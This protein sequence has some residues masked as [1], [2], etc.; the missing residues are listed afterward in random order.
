MCMQNLIISILTIFIIQMCFDA[1]N[2]QFPDSLRV[3][4]LHGMKFEAEEE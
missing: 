4:K 2:T 3:Q 1:L